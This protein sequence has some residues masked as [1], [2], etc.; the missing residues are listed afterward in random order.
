MKNMKRI[1]AMTLI[2]VV[3]SGSALAKD[4]PKPDADDPALAANGQVTEDVKAP[5]T[6]SF[7]KAA[8]MA[9]EARKKE[10]RRQTSDV[11]KDEK[12]VRSQTSDV[13]DNEADWKKYRTKGE[14]VE[15]R[16]RAD[17]IVRY[18]EVD[19]NGRMKLEKDEIL[20]HGQIV[21]YESVSRDETLAL[22]ETDE[23]KVQ[24]IQLGKHGGRLLKLTP[25]DVKGTLKTDETGEY[26]DVT[27]VDYMDPDPFGEYYDTRD[28]LAKAKGE[29]AR[30]GAEYK[31]DAA[32]SHDNITSDDPTTLMQHSKVVNREDYTVTS[33]YGLKD[34]EPG[35]KVALTG[36]C[37]MTI[38]TE[39]DLMEFWDKD[40][41]RATL[42][43]NGVYVPLGQ[44]CTILG[45]LQDDDTV[46]VDAMTSVE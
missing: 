9:S 25:F 39:K 37:V 44:R 32:Y 13:R 3:L 1:A 23:G 33:S 22:F 6:G 20:L 34:L 36:R 17:E 41:K 16:N 14:T 18:K 5:A 12:D 2:G 27:G 11:R 4:L 28:K 35:A 15:E 42:K 45:V 38:D 43:M 7:T 24:R 31:R 30:R 19:K 26:L 21:G 8:E 40:M 46:S 29:M 10:V